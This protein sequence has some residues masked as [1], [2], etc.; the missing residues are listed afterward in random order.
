M[1][2]YFVARLGESHGPYTIEALK[3]QNI[4]QD[5]LIW[6]EGLID[7]KRAEDIEEIRMTLFTP[8]SVPE[9]P[10]AEKPSNSKWLMPADG[11]VIT[12]FV[13]M[14]LILLTLGFFLNPKEAE[15]ADKVQEAQE[16][17][18]EQ[19]EPS[20][21]AE[22]ESAVEPAQTD[23]PTIRIGAQD[24]MTK[25]LNVSTFRN[26]DVIPQA[27][28]TEEW[29]AFWETEEPAW[30]YYE[31]DPANGEKYGKLYNWYAVR[32]S[33]G[34]APRGFHVPSDGEWTVL[35]DY[36]GG[37][38]IAGYKMKTKS[39]WYL[40]GT[41][42]NSSGFSGLPGGYRNYNGTFYNEGLY[43]YWW[44]SSESYSF[45]AWFRYLHYND[46]KVFRFD[47]PKGNGFSVRCLRD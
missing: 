5:T 28:S 26:G 33:R 21:K 16:H 7:W 3:D 19:S 32:D 22:S 47:N 9:N 45:F 41:S 6:Y 8:I 20:S 27:K 1:I 10:P 37:A 14:F 23:I 4:T 44:S 31:N 2:Q 35:T 40:D 30:C 43:G 36:L 24:W 17:N 12:V 34:L 42:T 46:G 38:D 18:P 29:E 11:I 15:Y 25:N 13:I 39:G